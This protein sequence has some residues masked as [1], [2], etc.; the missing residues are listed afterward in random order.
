[1]MI[2]KQFLKTALSWAW[3]NKQERRRIS[4]WLRA[5]KNNTWKLQSAFKHNVENKTTLIKNDEIMF[6]LSNIN[7]IIC[8]T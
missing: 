5:E 7:F 8:P 4:S 1:M 2:M 3:F 6:K